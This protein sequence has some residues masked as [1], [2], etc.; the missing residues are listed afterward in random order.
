[1]FMPVPCVRASSSSS[2]RSGILHK[3]SLLQKKKK[4]KKEEKNTP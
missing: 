2:I 4:K 1:M 3:T